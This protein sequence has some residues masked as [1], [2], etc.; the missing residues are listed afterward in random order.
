MQ[1]LRQ[2]FS[3][4][5]APR[6]RYIDGK[7]AGTQQATHRGLC[8]AGSRKHV[9]FDTFERQPCRRTSK[10]VYVIHAEDVTRARPTPRRTFSEHHPDWEGRWNPNRVAP[11]G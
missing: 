4:I 10:R 11:Q 2:L 5:Q 6:V 7:P 1:R 9:T 3:C 8:A